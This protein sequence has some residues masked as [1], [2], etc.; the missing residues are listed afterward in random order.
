M[1]TRLTIAPGGLGDVIAKWLQDGGGTPKGPKKKKGKDKPKA[2]PPPAANRAI[3]VSTFWKTVF[4]RLAR[5]TLL[6]Y[7]SLQDKKRCRQPW[8]QT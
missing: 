6:T 2:A 1:K 7:A 3:L 4:R 8:L 5:L